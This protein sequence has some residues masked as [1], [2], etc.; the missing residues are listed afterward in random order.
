MAPGRPRGFE[1]VG[2]MVR[3]LAV[4]GGFA[5]LLF[6]VVWWQRPEAQGPVQRVVDAP[7]VVAEA[8]PSSG[9][10]LWVPRGLPSGWQATSAWVEGAVS[11]GYDGVVV[12]VGYLT[13]SGSYAQ[14]RQTDGRSAQAVD[15]WT[16]GG[17]QTG[18]TT[19]SGRTWQTV[20]SSTAKALVL[21]D[22]GVTRVVGGKADWPELRVLASSLQPATAQADA[23]SEPAA[24]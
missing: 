20:E 15:D 6:L 21:V 1:T 19:V 5:L 23:S 8:A 24:S 13:P 9:F 14:F 2:D 17:R 16:G 11:S 10:E 18:E 7:A 12:H 3:S 4:V 22:G